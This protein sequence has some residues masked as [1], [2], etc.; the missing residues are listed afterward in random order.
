MYK[1]FEIGDY[2]DIFDENEMIPFTKSVKI[3]NIKSDQNKII[4]IGK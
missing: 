4:R 3:I 2:I 1:S